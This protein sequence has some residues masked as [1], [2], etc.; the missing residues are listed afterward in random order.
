MVGLS[1]DGPT[2][3]VTM[4]RHTTWSSQ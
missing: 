3:T 2:G 1:V 4:S